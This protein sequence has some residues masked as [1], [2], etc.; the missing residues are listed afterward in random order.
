MTEDDVSSMPGWK[1]FLFPGSLLPL[2][3]NWSLFCCQGGQSYF[4]LAKCY[5]VVLSR[6]QRHEMEHGR[7]A[8]ARA[9]HGPVVGKEVDS[10]C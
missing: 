10:S 1:L 3:T 9:C 5:L 8:M 2:A 4:D 7:H 6:L